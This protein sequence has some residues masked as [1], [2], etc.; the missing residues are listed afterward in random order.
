M[1]GLCI[2]IRSKYIW[3]SSMEDGHGGGSTTTHSMTTK[4]TYHM[5]FYETA[6]MATIIFLAVYSGAL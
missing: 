5:L 3:L 1:A 2:K 4:F 6:V